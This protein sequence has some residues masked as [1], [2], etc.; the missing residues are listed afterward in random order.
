MLVEKAHLAI[1]AGKPHIEKVAGPE[2]AWAELF[3]EPFLPPPVLLIAGAGHIAAPLA[4]VAHL[5]R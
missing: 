5:F 3:I 4:Y 1:S 2:S